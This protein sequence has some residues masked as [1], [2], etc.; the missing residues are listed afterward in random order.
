MKSHIK[1]TGLEIRYTGT[2]IHQ[3][4]RA[5]RRFWVGNLARSLWGRL[6]SAAGF[7]RLLFAACRYGGQ[8]GN[9]RPTV[10]RP[11]AAFASSPEGRLTIGRR[12]P[13]APRQA[14]HP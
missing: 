8:A 9:L 2:T 7:S 12:L 6:Q 3:F 14:S 1:E 11:L 5:P 13:A 10:N 4:L